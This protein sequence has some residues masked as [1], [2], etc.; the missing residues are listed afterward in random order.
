M[1]THQEKSGFTIRAAFI[2]I[3]LSIFL[4]MSTSYIA[5]KL[6]AAPWPIIFSVIVSTSVI[7]L[8]NRRRELNIHEVNVAQAG[9]SIGGLVAAGIAFTLPGLFKSDKRITY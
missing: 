1:N 6:G 3:A 7:K 5:L 2:A 8:L 4:L 9:G